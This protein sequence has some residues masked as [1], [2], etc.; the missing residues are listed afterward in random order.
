MDKKLI[1]ST[2]N[3]MGIPCSIQYF[4]TIS[5]TNDYAKEL[6]RENCPENTVII[7]EK[8]T[9][10]RGR[11]GRTFFSPEK[12][13]LYTSIIIRPS[14]KA[15]DALF[16][17]P[18][19]A[20]ALNKVFEKLYGIETEIKWVNDIY[21]NGKKICGILT[22]SAFKND[23]TLDYVIVG[24]GINLVKPENGFPDEISE[25][26]GCVFDTPPE[27]PEKLCAEIISSVITACNDLSN[28]DFLN[29]YKSRQMLTGKRVILPSEEEVTVLGVDDHC[30]L[31]VKDRFGKTLTIS[32]GDVSVK[33]VKN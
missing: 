3:G 18:A 21:K 14:F 4:E 33:I 9:R 13:G 32:S 17:T 28:K 7:A 30:A 12:T 15:E 31:I 24:I 11:M 27:N 2:L 8:Q 22:E 5:S 26:A 19:T 20:V 23:G 6:A 10:G 1:E 16:I 25:I 29:T